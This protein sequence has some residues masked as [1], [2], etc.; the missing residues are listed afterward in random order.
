M[1][2]LCLNGMYY[3]VLACFF[4]LK[5]TEIEEDS[6]MQQQNVETIDSPE[7]PEFTSTSPAVHIKSAARSL[8]AEMS[9]QQHHEQMTEPEDHLAFTSKS[10]AVHR[11]RSSVAEM[12]SSQ[13]QHE[14]RI[15]TASTLRSP[16]VHTKGAAP[17]KSG[18]ITSAPEQRDES[19]NT[20]GIFSTI[21]AILWIYLLF[22]S[23]IC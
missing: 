5:F 18:S 20:Q 11:K 7:P 12:P 1:M 4:L 8:V 22:T 19:F 10:P 6:S 21:N 15:K 9:S 23:M 17:S 13:L 3:T 2:L 16:A 14:E